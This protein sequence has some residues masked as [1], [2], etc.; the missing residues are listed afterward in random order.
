MAGRPKTFTDAEVREILAAIDDPETHL[1]SSCERGFLAALDGSCRTPLAGLAEVEGE[2]VR[3]SGQVLTIDGRNS[4]SVSRAFAY[5]AL[6]H[7]TALAQSY[8]AGEGAAD[9]L[10]RLFSGARE[11]AAGQIA[12]LDC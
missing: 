3:F 12:I 8:A 11:H 9:E 1:A 6:S 10:R 7:E 2:M 4:W 5:A